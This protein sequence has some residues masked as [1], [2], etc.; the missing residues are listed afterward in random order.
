MFLYYSEQVPQ[1][2]VQQNKNVNIKYEAPGL[3]LLFYSYKLALFRLFIHNKPNVSQI[4][5]SIL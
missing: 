5:K 3:F 1:N 2:K 4:N